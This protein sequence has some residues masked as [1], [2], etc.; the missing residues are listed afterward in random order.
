M[1]VKTESIRYRIFGEQ[2]L[3][4][5]NGCLY[6]PR[7][8]FIAR[9]AAV[10]Q[11]PTNARVREGHVREGRPTIQWADPTDRQVD[12][13][14]EATAADR[15]VVGAAADRLLAVQCHKAVVAVVAV[16]HR[17]T[18]TDPADWY[19]PSLCGIRGF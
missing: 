19:S 4:Q 8:G 1:K 6:I 14:A 17:Q 12:R 13:Q 10:Q 2:M 15:Q 18:N 7:T 11:Y 3:I 5:S 9:V 16:E